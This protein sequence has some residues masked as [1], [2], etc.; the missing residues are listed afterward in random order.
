VF[1]GKEVFLIHS[2]GFK[3]LFFV[4]FEVLTAVVMK[5]SI[6]YVIR[7]KSTDVTEENITSIF[8]VEEKA[9]Q[10]TIYPRR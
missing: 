6:F 1:A 4:G 2:S 10:E 5:I 9:K 3:L 8:G 7:S